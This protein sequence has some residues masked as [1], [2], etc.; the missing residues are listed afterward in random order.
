MR[1]L[2]ED[3][4]SVV[5]A[6]DRRFWPVARRNIAVDATYAW[7]AAAFLG[8]ALAPADWPWWLAGTVVNHATVTV[9]GLLPRSTLLGHNLRRLPDYPANRD[10]VALTFDDGPDP[11]ETP[12]VLDLL[13][14][15]GAKATF[16]CIGE[17]ARQHPRIVQDIVA[18]GHCVENHS[19]HHRHTFSVS[20]PARIR[21]EVLAGQQTLKTL[22]GQTAVFFRAPAGLRN[23]FLDPILQQA[24][25]RLASWTRRGF[26]TREADPDKVARRLLD[27]LAPRDILLL[28]DRGAARLPGSDDSVALVVLPRVLQ[29]IAARQLRC[30]TL[31]EG[32][33]DPRR[34]D[35][36]TG[37]GAG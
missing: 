4:D 20:L 11:E 34:A 32:F 16:F 19:Q 24:D 17:R 7:H 23:L 21:A 2:P 8:C 30:V 22:T 28:H 14:A 27:D 6:P 10:A 1:I 18:R 15:A 5:S 26:D 3:D 29:A 31:R 25:L 9:A 13:D 37:A 35:T 33:S 12:R 36:D